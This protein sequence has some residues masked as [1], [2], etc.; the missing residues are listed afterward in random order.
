MFYNLVLSLKLNVLKR[1]FV[2]KKF[3]QTKSK[4]RFNV[5]LYLKIFVKQVLF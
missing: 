2:L 3:L 4:Q 1:K 5:V